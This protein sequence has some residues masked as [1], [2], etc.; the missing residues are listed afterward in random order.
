MS[1][2]YGAVHAA[3]ADQLHRRVGLEQALDGGDVSID[4]RGV[5]PAG[6]GRAAPAGGRDGERACRRA[7]PDR[8]ACASDTPLRCQSRAA[9][10]SEQRWQGIGLH[11]PSATWLPS[12]H[13]DGRSSESRQ[14]GPT[15]TKPAV[16]ELTGVGAA[17][18]AVHAGEPLG[19]LGVRVRAGQPLLPGAPK[20]ASGLSSEGS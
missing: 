16:V 9:A 5:A 20:H 18:A 14:H 2:F 15:R 11:L 6:L 17:A 1:L 19:V 13:S 7:R 3:E 10:R 12:A 4:E 8:L